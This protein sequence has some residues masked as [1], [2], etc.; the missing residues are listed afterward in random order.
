ML[1]L[2]AI[3][4][5]SFPKLF[6]SLFLALISGISD[7]TLTSVSSVSFNFLLHIEHE[8]SPKTSSILEPRSG[9]HKTAEILATF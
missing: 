3:T 5:D 9:I 1:F 8:S 7:N 6:F 2:L 4:E